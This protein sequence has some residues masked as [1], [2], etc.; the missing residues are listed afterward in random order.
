MRGSG[1]LWTR[2]SAKGKAGV[3]VGGI[4]GLSWIGSIGSPPRDAAPVAGAGATPAPTRAITVTPRPTATAAPAVSPKAKPKRTPK[5]TRKPASV[6][7]AN[8]T[9][10]R[11]AGAAPIYRGEPGYRSALDR[12]NDGVACE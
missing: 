11:G 1:A 4:L 9:E 7:Y 2:R 12:D 5:P 10:A 3:L 6:Y 8:C